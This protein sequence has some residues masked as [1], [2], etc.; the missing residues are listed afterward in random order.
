M[1]ITPDQRATLQLLLERGQS[2]SDLAA[3]LQVE[4]AEVRA[5]ARAALTELG[6]SDPDRNVALTDYVLGQAD[7][8]GRADAS[9]H[10]RD[11]A[12]DHALATEL[13]ARLRELFPA[14]ELPRLPGEPRQGRL[15][16]RRPP[17]P[18]SP[19]PAADKPRRPARLAELS[20][21]QSRLLVALGSGALLLIVVVLAVAGVFSGD[22]SESSASGGEQTTAEEVDAAAEEAVPIEL[23]PVGGSDAGGVVVFG[24]ASADQPFIEFQ[25]RN[26]EPPTNQ[27]AYVLW[28][29][30]EGGERGFPLPSAIP[31][32]A[33][34]TISDRVAI[35]AEVIAYAEQAETIT[36]ALND[37]RELDD[38]INRAIRQRQGALPYPG[39]TVLSARIP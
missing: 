6:G 25:I 10:L 28:F 21:Q 9:R 34:G 39:G 38:S 36:I 32:N 24:L 2:Y 13:T 27:D 33:N 17:P 26:L 3:L 16:R 31:V 29:L 23:R 12:A 11:D 1:P 37:R 14:A 19:R 4:E 35:P 5:R 8:I 30:S 7:P 18:A 20:Q 15:A 22:G